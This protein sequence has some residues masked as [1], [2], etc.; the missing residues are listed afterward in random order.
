[1][2][3]YKIHYTY[4]TKYQHPKYPLISAR[5]HIIRWL[6][7]KRPPHS[8]DT[9]PRKKTFNNLDFWSMYDNKCIGS[10]QNGLFHV[11]MQ[12]LSSSSRDAWKWFFDRFFPLLHFLCVSFF[13]LCLLLSFINSRRSLF[14]SCFTHSAALLGISYSVHCSGS[15]TVAFVCMQVRGIVHYKQ[16]EHSMRKLPSAW[17]KSFSSHGM[18]EYAL[19]CNVFMQL[20]GSTYAF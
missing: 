16:N 6:I 20:A 15:V 3:W 9:F 10:Q 4:T 8:S 12:H 7:R 18:C 13:Y 19:R 11:R 14:V 2:Q 1:M 5:I 17:E